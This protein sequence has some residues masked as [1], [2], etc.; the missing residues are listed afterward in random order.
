MYPSSSALLKI[1]AKNV[2]R[3]TMWNCTTK[4]FTSC[5]YRLVS[6]DRL[7]ALFLLAFSFSLLQ[8]SVSLGKEKCVWFLK[9]MDQELNF[10]EKWINENGLLGFRFTLDREWYG[11]DDL[12]RRKRPVRHLRQEIFQYPHFPA[13][14]ESRWLWF[15]GETNIS[16]RLPRL[17]VRLFA[18]RLGQGS[19][20]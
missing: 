9:L 18:P 17:P 14:Q 4:E 11:N 12:W 13:A 8:Q 2:A 7:D 3:K 19:L 6:C 16:V 10:C 5:P 15:S 1:V 20:R